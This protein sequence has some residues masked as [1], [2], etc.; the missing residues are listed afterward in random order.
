MFKVGL[1]AEGTHDFIMLSP[2]IAHE[3]AK[4]SIHEVV[5]RSLQP[6]QDET[7]KMSGGGWSRVLSWCQRYNGPALDTFFAPLFEGDAGC[8]AIVIHLDGDALALIAPHTTVA[9]PSPNPDIKIRV[10]TIA[11]A[12]EGWLATDQE[13]RQKLALAIPVLSS[14]AWILAAESFAGDP[15]AV[16]AKV[17]FRKEHDFRTMKLEHYYA[18]RVKKATEPLAVEPSCDSYCAFAIEISNLKLP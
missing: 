13:R 17:E 5:F 9:I 1:V 12:I 10:Q 7:G 16:D 4:L 11:K 2:L 3:L 6:I 18:Q 14:E 8:D 15:S